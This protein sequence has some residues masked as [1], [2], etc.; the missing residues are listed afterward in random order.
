VGLGFHKFKVGQ[1]VH[2][3]G[4]LQYVT[5]VRGIYKIVRLL[6]SETKDCQYRIQSTTDGHERVV[7]ESEIELR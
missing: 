5:T 2:F 1:S 6:P 3:V 7:R 4:G